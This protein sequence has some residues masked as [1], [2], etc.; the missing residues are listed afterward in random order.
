MHLMSNAYIK[1]WVFHMY[2]D[3]QSK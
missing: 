3:C 2:T 1:Y